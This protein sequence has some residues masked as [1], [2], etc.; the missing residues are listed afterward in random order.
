MGVR[1]EDILIIWVGEGANLC[2]KVGRL[3]SPYMCG[4][5][6]GQHHIHVDGWNSRIHPKYV[7]GRWAKFM[8]KGGKLEITLHVWVGEE[9]TPYS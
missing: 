9:P 4:W 3:K 5:G 2:A 1:H 6:K 8:Q 7:G